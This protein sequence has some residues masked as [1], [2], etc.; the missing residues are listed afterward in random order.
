M[1]TTISIQPPVLSPTKDDSHVSCASSDTR[2]TTQMNDNNGVKASFIAAV[3]DVSLNVLK[4]KSI[5]NETAKKCQMVSTGN[6]LLNASSAN[7][8]VENASTANFCM[9]QTTF[10]SSNDISNTAFPIYETETCMDKVCDENYVA[11][12]PDRSEEA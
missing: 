3:A 6:I 5:K 10:I 11:N 12:L 9:P 1:P 7:N 4:M 2:S 8:P